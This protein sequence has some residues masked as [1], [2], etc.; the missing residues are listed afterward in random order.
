MELKVYL[1]SESNLTIGVKLDLTARKATKIEH[2]SKSSETRVAA[3]E[4]IVEQLDAL[5]TE[6]L[7]APVQIFINSH[8]YTNITNGYYKYWLI[9]GENSEGEKISEKEMELW[10]KFLVLSSEKSL[11]VI[12][13]DAMKATIKYKKRVSRNYKET[14]LDKQNTKYISWSWEKLKE[15]VGDTPEVDDEDIEVS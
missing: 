8:M 9:T 14:K 10:A 5:D 11:Y 2:R 12:F 6:K 3:L 15:L 7:E 4:A 13:K 1:A